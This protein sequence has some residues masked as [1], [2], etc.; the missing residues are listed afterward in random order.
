MEEDNQNQESNQE[1]AH[2]ATESSNECTDENKTEQNTS[3]ECTSNTEIKIGIIGGSGIDQ[4]DILE[5][6]ITTSIITKFGQPS[7]PIVE[8]TINNTKVAIIARH[9]I[10]HKINPTNVNYRANIQALKQIGCTHIIAATAV[11]SLQEHIKPGEIL[12]ADQF[13]DRTTKRKQTFYEEDKVCHISIAKPMC[14]TLRNQLIQSCQELNLEF[15]KS[16]TCVVIEGPRFSTLAESNMF[17]SWNADIIG[18]TMVPEVVLAREAQLPYVNIS[19]V[20]DYDVWKEEEVTTEAVIQTMKQNA[21]KLKKLL[22]HVIPKIQYD[23]DNSIRS[24]LKSAM[25]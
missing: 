2:C 9:G 25:F 20:T 16:G 12:L 21:E 8:G 18:M 13:I 14:E 6:R 17:R 22:L 15:H 5:N 11:G 7:S 19:M 23:K 1:T 24:A 4:P 10:G 3:Q